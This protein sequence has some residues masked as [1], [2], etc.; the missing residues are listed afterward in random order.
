MHANGIRDS[1]LSSRKI[2]VPGSPRF[3]Q[4][5]PP[6]LGPSHRA[7][8]N[9]PTPLSPT[10]QTPDK[11]QNKTKTHPPKDPTNTNPHTPQLKKTNTPPTPHPTCFSLLCAPSQFFSPFPPT[12]F[13]ISAPVFLT[14]PLDL[15]TSVALVLVF[16]FCCTQ[17]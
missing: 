3:Q 5:S 9:H 15:I 17:S 7:P 8:P 14:P 1:R 2:Q 4:K 6:A 10:R 12:Y 16:P 13:S 11:N